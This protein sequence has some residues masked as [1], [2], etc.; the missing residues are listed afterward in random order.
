MIITNFLGY[1]GF[2][3][4][5]CFLRITT[6]KTE[7]S[8]CVVNKFL[9]DMWWDLAPQFPPPSSCKKKEKENTRL[10]CLIFC[11]QF[12]KTDCRVDLCPRLLFMNVLCTAIII[13]ITI[14]INIG[15]SDIAYATQR[16]VY[17]ITRTANVLYYCDQKKQDSKWTKCWLYS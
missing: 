4:F 7:I 17:N 14:I 2:G 8:S 16:T 3:W 10:G 11:H 6:K 12:M 9:S 13:I 1:Q 15:N 5:P